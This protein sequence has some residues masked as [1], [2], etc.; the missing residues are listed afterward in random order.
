MT[1]HYYQY[2]VVALAWDDL[3]ERFN[4]TPL[5]K[6]PSMTEA[7]CKFLNMLKKFKSID[8]S[9]PKNYLEGFI[10]KIHKV[11]EKETKLHSSILA[12]DQTNQI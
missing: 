3:Q 12:N 9:V 1:F 5:S 7:I 2:Q 11:N 8:T 10:H 6:I 4:G